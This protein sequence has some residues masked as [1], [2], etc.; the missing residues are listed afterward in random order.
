MEI[1]DELASMPDALERSFAQVPVEAR[2]WEPES[3]DGFPGETFSAS[4]QVCHVRDIEIEGYR[5]RFTRLLTEEQP[6]LVSIDSYALARE[7]RYGGQ[8]PVAALSDFRKARALTV[9]TLRGLRSGDWS[10]RGEFE[11]YGPVTLAGLAHF[12]RSHDQQHLAC[13]HWLLGKIRSS[14]ATPLGGC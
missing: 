3:W 12:L 8:D 4:G 5:V 14:A 2:E 13:M 10:R 6:L 9:G 11:G 7:R 1:I